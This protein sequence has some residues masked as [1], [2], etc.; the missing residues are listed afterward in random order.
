M[1]TYTYSDN[2]YLKNGYVYKNV[3]VV[4]TLDNNLIIQFNLLRQSIPVNEIRAVTYLPLIPG[5]IAVLLEEPNSISATSETTYIYQ[6]KDSFDIQVATLRGDTFRAAFVKSSDSSVTYLTKQGQMT[7]KKAEILSATKIRK[8]KSDV[9][10]SKT[11][12]VEIKEYDKLPLLIFAIGGGVWTYDL[13]SKSNDLSNAADVFGKL[14]MQDAKLKAQQDSDQKLI[15]GLAV[16]TVSLIIFIVS[17]QPTTNVVEQP[18]SVIM[19]N[20][21]IKLCLRF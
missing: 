18:I 2:V 14:N 16:G 17:V 10:K 7:L 13:I 1:A 19:T 6:Q 20:D 11:T 5:S 4:D 3:V 15:E 12:K 9:Y 21:G 8:E